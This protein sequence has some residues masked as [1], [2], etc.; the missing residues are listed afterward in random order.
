[1][2][3]AHL[4]WANTLPFQRLYWV[5]SSFSV[6]NN[7]GNLLSLRLHPQ[8]WQRVGFCDS[9]ATVRAGTV[10]HLLVPFLRPAL[11]DGSLIFLASGTRRS[12]VTHQPEKDDEP[13]D[14]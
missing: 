11:A 9:C 12:C 8:S 14:E 2:V 1:V 6:F 13:T 5:S 10:A 7:L 3:V 4:P